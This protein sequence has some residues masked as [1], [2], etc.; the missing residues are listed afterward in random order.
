MRIIL[1]IARGGFYA[2]DVP[3]ASCELTETHLRSAF[4][5]LGLVTE[6][7][8]AE[9]VATGPDQRVAAIRDAKAQIA[10]IAA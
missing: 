8:V 1:G 5:F 2:G 3:M 4:G 9:G 6:S 10:A 7:L